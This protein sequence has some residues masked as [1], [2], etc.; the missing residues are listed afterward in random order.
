VG[1]RVPARQGRGGGGDRDTWLDL[2]SRTGA[3]VTEADAASIARVRE[4]LEATAREWFHDE[5]GGCAARS[6]AR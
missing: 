6:T 5:A 4:D 1:Q 2:V 3:A